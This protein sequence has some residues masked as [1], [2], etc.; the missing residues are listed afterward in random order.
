M[1]ACLSDLK[2]DEIVAGDSA[3]DPHLDSCARC[4]A[5][6]AERR[7]AQMA[8]RDGASPLYAPRP[9]RRWVP[10]AASGGIAVAALAVV[11]VVTRRPAADEPGTRTKGA[12]HASASVMIASGG[13]AVPLRGQANAGDT[14]AYLVTTT[15]PSYV[16]VLSRDPTGT[17]ST[18]FPKTEL[19]E[20]VPVGREVELPLATRLDA[21][22]GHEQ[23]VI[24]VCPNPVAIA[25]LIA[26]FDGDPPG[27]CTFERTSF[28]KLPGV[29]TK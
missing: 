21:T 10:L 4:A 15:E 1:T 9:A 16:A 5:R 19:A 24:A 18:Y 26:A 29:D 20:A 8:F 23:L 14:L 7:A 2:L 6:E 12:S 25:E 17:M 13:H 22:P 11:V 28:D 27:G 3:R